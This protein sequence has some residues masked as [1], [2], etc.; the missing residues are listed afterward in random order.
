M[1]NTYDVRHVKLQVYSDLIYLLGSLWQAIL[2][3]SRF[4]ECVLE[5]SENFILVRALIYLNS[6]IKWTYCSTNFWNIN[7]FHVN[8]EEFSN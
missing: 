6:Y 3:I 1:R 2:S 4:I 7:L 8:I 5:L